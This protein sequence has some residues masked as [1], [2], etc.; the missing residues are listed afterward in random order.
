MIKFFRRIRKQLLKE[1][2]TADYIKYALGEI[3]LVVIGIL[4]ALYINTRYEDYKL[5]K[6]ENAL[7]V[8]L[9]QEFLK[10]KN[11]FEEAIVGHEQLV[12]DCDEIIKMFP[13]S[14]QTL[15]FDKLEF[16]GYK[17]F[18]EY[19]FTP[20]QGIINSI[21]S[22][23]SFNIIANDTLRRRLITWQDLVNDYTRDKDNAADFFHNYYRPY[24]INNGS[25]LNFRNPKVDPSFIESVVFENMV[26][27][28]RN[29]IVI[30]TGSTYVK[31]LREAIDEILRLTKTE[32]H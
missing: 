4:I 9:H 12:K 21:I 27:R 15:D 6:Q 13:I 25:V 28:R 10:N 8:E 29:S 24:L 22:T 30:I 14:L 23:S 7:L 31:N 32:N 2:R 17:T 26:A 16:H 20:S 1:G 11:E 19:D 18:L 3:F 5:S